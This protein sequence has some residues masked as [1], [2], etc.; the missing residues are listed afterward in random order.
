MRENRLRVTPAI[1]AGI[2]III[3]SILLWKVHLNALWSALQNLNAV[4]ILPA[5]A[6]AL[7]SLAI[8][9]IKWQRLLHAAGSRASQGDIV[10]SLFGGFALGVVTPGRLGEFGR[11]LFTP[12]AERATVI[13]LNIIDRVL[14]SWSVATYAVVSLLLTG[15]LPLGIIGLAGWAAFIPAL[16]SSPR[17]VFRLGNSPRWGKILGTRLPHAG[18]IL[19]KSAVAVFAGWALLSTTLDIVTFYF[20]LRAFRPTG[21]MAAPSTY[22]WMM[23]ASGIPV[24]LGGLGL[25]EGAA[26]AL[27]H[28]YAFPAAEAAEAALLLFALLSLLPALC[29]GILL[30]LPRKAN[31]AP[32]VALSDAG[33]GRNLS[34]DLQTIGE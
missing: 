15:T 30:F 34:E 9:A 1:R 13:P 33:L 12:E 26:V 3:F 24:T 18:P 5:L 21:F 2:S 32:N 19:G 11:C 20:L 27:L 7:A 23:M 17:L 14:D 8:R 6:C 28:H 16:L 4:W 29:G 25:R 31:K 22:P 10:R